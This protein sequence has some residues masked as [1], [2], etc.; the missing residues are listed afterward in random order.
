MRKLYSKCA[1]CGQHA[2][3]TNGGYYFCTNEKCGYKEHVII[4]GKERKEGRNERLE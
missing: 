3:L 2:Y 4:N 1:K